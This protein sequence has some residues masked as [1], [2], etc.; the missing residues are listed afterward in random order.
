MGVPARQS[1]GCTLEEA[2]TA[3]GDAV[4]EADN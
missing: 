4:P 3:G 2:E 1:S